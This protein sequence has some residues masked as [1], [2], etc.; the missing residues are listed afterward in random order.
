MID[1]IEYLVKVYPVGYSI[2][3]RR[4]VERVSIEEK[5]PSLSTYSDDYVIQ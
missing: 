1:E 5:Y 4:P 2:D 3:I